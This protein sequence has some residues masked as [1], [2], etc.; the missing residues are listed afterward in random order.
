MFGAT[1][2]VEFGAETRVEFGAETRS[3]FGAGPEGGGED[4]AHEVLR[5]NSIVVH[6]HVSN[7]KS[8]SAKS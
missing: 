8:H 2:R 7:V 1:P 3:E 5:R 6:T 4:S